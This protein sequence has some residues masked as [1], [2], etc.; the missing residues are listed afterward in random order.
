[1]SIK[2][3]I[4][5]LGG[6]ISYLLGGWDVM[7]QTLVYLAVAD[8]LTGVLAGIYTNKLSSQ[9]G[10]KGIIKK[11]CMFCVI[12]LAS[13]VD[14]AV[15][16]ELVRNITIVFY[17]SNEGISILENVGRTGVKYP[18]KLKQILEQLNKKDG[19]NK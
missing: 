17:I 5:T 11:V 6:F 13:V 18:D 7:L 2:A 14:M 9:V 4:G 16:T 3:T 19:E 12:G 10:Y 8:Y 15:N 1:M